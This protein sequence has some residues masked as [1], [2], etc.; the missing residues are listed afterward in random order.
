[1][2]ISSSESTGKDFTKLCLP[3]KT[4]KLVMSADITCANYLEFSNNVPDIDYLEEL[5]SLKTLGKSKKED[6]FIST[7]N[8]QTSKIKFQDLFSSQE[9][10]SDEIS[11]TNEIASTCKRKSITEGLVQLQE[12]AKKKQLRKNTLSSD[13]KIQCTLIKELEKSEIKFAESLSIIQE[14]FVDPLKAYFAHASVG[15]YRKSEY[16][17]CFHFKR[18]KYHPHVFALFDILEQLYSVHREFKNAINPKDFDEI[19]EFD[20]HNKISR[21]FS[22]YFPVLRTLYTQYWKHYNMIFESQGKIIN[23]N[24]DMFNYIK[25]LEGHHEC[26]NQTFEQFLLAVKNRISDYAQLAD[27]LI[28]SDTGAA[29]SLLDYVNVAK[30]SVEQESMKW[31]KELEVVDLSKKFKN[32][33]LLKVG[34]FVLHEGLAQI[35]SFK[36]DHRDECEPRNFYVY[37]LS[38]LLIICQVNAIGTKVFKE[39]IELTGQLYTTRLST[40]SEF[41]FAMPSLTIEIPDTHTNHIITPISD[42]HEWK[43]AFCYLHNHFSNSISESMYI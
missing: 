27:S 2:S 22:V 18:E 28:N 16:G 43:L 20:Y 30:I 17:N 4:D 37:I 13:K 10:P 34:R 7:Y 9:D 40:N 36:T 3:V 1:M 25:R 32:A 19:N 15:E 29:Q 21:V 6:E 8:K 11:L 14:F 38:D 42:L 33:A 35:Q 24:T 26:N 12:L 41:N 39:K 5:E 31:S 23:E